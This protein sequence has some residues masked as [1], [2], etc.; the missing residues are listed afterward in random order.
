MFARTMSTPRTGSV[1]V[2]PVRSERGWS[3]RAF[4]RSRCA[5]RR[6]ETRERAESSSERLITAGGRDRR[7][8]AALSSRRL[9]TPSLRKIAVRWASTVRGLM[10]SLA[11]RSRFDAPLDDEAG[12]LQLVRREQ[13]VRR[14]VVADDAA[15]RPQLRR[16]PLGEHGRARSRA[17]S[18]PRAR[19]GCAPRPAG[20]PAAAVRPTRSRCARRRRGCPPQAAV[21]GPG[22]VLRCLV[23]VGREHPL[24]TAEPVRTSSS[25]SA[26]DPLELARRRRRPRRGGRCEPAPRPTPA[27]SAQARPIGSTLATSR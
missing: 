26:S 10:N 8:P 3:G 20:G 12:D 23:V 2:G 7:S 14:H 11:A 15:G 9:R 17:G 27:P 18:R 1:P 21:D 24:G 4:R 19:G 25:S 6:S 5:A 16:R 13:L 22:E